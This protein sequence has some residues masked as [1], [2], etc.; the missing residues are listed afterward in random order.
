MKLT[1]FFVLV[2]AISFVGC[3]KTDSNAS[4]KLP[5]GFLDAPKPGETIRG[6]Y[7]VVG[8][9]LAESGVEK[10]SIYVDRN[11]VGQATLAQKR[12]DLEHPPYSTFPN[13]GSGG[14]VYQWDTSE[15]TPGSHE[16]L[17]QAR[18]NDGATRDLGFAPITVAH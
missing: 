15:V 18:T 10:V 14:F 4:A 6:T 7:Q 2:S 3:G 12:P 8:W 17:V 16:L 5:V 11:F 1:V 9:A 13:P